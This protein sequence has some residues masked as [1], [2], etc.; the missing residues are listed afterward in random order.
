VRDLLNNLRYRSPHVRQHAS[1]LGGEG[2]LQTARALPRLDEIA[3]SQ[4]RSRKT[5]D[6]G[7]IHERSRRLH[8]VERKR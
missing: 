6:D 5:F 4:N 8:Q 2:W 3:G 7:P 1:K